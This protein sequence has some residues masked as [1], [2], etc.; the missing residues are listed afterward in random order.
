MALLTEV[1]STEIQEN[2]YMG[3]EFMKMATDHSMGKI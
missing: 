2:L 3:N 1:W